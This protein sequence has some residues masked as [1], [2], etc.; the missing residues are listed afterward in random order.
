MKVVSVWI[1]YLRDFQCFA[2]L[3]RSNQMSNFE[4][5]FCLPNATTLTTEQS[6]VYSV[7]VTFCWK[8]KTIITGIPRDICCLYTAV[9]ECNITTKE[10]K[11][12]HLLTFAS[13]L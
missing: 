11:M 12:S 8:K 6:G 2:F 13:L 5:K 3:L 10:K 4:F 9:C 7:I 1:N